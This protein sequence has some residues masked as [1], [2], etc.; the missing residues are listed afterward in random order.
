M[1]LLEPNELAELGETLEKIEIID[2]CWEL[3]RGFAKTSVSA[4]LAQGL[5]PLILT[6]S[7]AL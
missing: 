1:L 5:E 2:E 7:L 6:F 3:D 4:I